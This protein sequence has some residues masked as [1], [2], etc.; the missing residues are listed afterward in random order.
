MK[1]EF[2]KQP[3]PDKNKQISDY[4]INPE[5]SIGQIRKNKNEGDM[6]IKSWYTVGKVER[7]FKEDYGLNVRIF[8]KANDGW[9]QS[10]DKDQFKIL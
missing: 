5:K 10:A 6:Q 8:R 1:I 7:A 4:L 2:Y 9:I 3:H